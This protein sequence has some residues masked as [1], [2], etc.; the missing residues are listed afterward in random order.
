MTRERQDGRIHLLVAIVLA[1]VALFLLVVTMRGCFHG[2]AWVLGHNSGPGW[3]MGWSRS[4]AGLLPFGLWFV[5]HLVL[6]FWVGSDADKKGQNGLLWGLLVFF[7][8]I[9]GL[10]VYLIVV[11]WMAERN[12][13]G[14]LAGGRTSASTCPSCHAAMRP[15]YK[16]CPH[17][18]ASLRCPQCSQTV[19]G[20]WNVCPFCTTRLKA[21]PAE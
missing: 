10:I 19:Q 13:G 2:A 14:A 12:G 6:A 11:P 20:D 9:V 5:I 15:E 7:T 1:V 21:G 4:G 17:C 18:G 3:L 16:A 8:G